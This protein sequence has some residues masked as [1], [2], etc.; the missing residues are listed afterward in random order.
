MM[1]TEL[2]DCVQHRAAID[3]ALNRHQVPGLTRM[4]QLYKAASE[5]VQYATPVADRTMLTGH[6][7]TG[8]HNI[9]TATDLR[10]GV[11]V[12]LASPITNPSNTL[13]TVGQKWAMESMPSAESS[14][15]TVAYW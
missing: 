9:G 3:A 10:T 14:T 11:Y 8:S 2:N 1:T 6:M 12:Q 13:L 15:G 4:R 5:N 7:V